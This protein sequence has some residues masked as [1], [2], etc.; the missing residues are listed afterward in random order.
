M[1][2]SDRGGTSQRYRL[3][4]L[5]C[6]LRGHRSFRTETRE[7]TLNCADL[8]VVNT[9]PYGTQYSTDRLLKSFPASAK[10]VLYMVL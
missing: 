8:Y 5:G 3:V 10:S 7:L 4:L 2:A 9:R 6:S 1:M